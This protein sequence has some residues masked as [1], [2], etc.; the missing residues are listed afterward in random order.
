MEYLYVFIQ[1]GAHSGSYISPCYI[2]KF[3][4]SPLPAPSPFP[5]SLI[6]SMRVE[7]PSPS[8]CKPLCCRVSVRVLRVQTLLELTELRTRLLD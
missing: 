3:F 4:G 5:F 8:W 7:K 6:A 2:L 1:C